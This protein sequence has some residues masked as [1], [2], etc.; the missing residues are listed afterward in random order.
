MKD[1]DLA[2]RAAKI[3]GK[4]LEEYF[5]NPKI[6]M[7]NVRDLVTN[8]DIDSENAI[9]EFLLGKTDYG[10]LGEETG[11]KPG[12]KIWAVDPLDG[13]KEFSFGIPHFSV[14]IA[15][16]SRNGTELGVVY[17]PMINKMFT[18]EI[19][20]GAFMNKARLRQK[21]EEK[22]LKDAL[23]SCCFEYERKEISQINSKAGI[24]LIN[25][26][27]AASVCNTIAGKSDAAVYGLTRIYDHAAPGLIA[28]EAG[29][30]VTN[31]GLDSWNPENFG[32]VAAKEGLHKELMKIF[33]EPL[34]ILLKSEKYF[35]PIKPDFI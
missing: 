11:T 32:I 25:F 27:A 16:V 26:S 22:T 5:E 20:K 24:C 6:S 34:E 4:I 7:K 3:G 13:T 2:V 33:P 30:K 14:C 8:A 21:K 10:F 17:N 19:G 15:L 12:K 18:A 35:T 29:L 28:Q 23:V 9:R 31:F 1:I